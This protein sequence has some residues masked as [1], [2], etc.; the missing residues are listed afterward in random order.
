VAQAVRR[1]RVGVARQQQSFR[2]RE[3]GWGSLS[4]QLKNVRYQAQS[5]GVEGTKRSV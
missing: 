4:T 5:F 2:L 3:A 1:D